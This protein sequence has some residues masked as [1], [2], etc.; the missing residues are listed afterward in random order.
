MQGS[1]SSQQD[2]LPS[3]LPARSAVRGS[4]GSQQPHH[5]LSAAA[6][7]AEP[8]S[9]LLRSDRATSQQALLA[10]LRLTEELG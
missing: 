7:T 4:A 6:R 1:P 2:V 10:H 5:L 8:I 9:G 3:A